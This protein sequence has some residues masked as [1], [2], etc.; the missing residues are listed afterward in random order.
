[1][2][3]TFTDRAQESMHRN[4]DIRPNLKEGLDIVFLL[5]ICISKDFYS[6]H[7]YSHHEKSG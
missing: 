7:I 3:D 2:E 4:S 6:Q 1:M 5:L